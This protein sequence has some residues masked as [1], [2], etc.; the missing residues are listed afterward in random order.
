MGNQRLSQ[1]ILCCLRGVIVWPVL[2]GWNDA[3]RFRSGRTPRLQTTS[4]N[5][6]S[7]RFHRRMVFLAAGNWKCSGCRHLVWTYRTFKLEIRI[8]HTKVRLQA[9]SPGCEAA[10]EEIQD[11]GNW[12]LKTQNK[13]EVN[14]KL[15]VRTENCKAK[16]LADIRLFL[17]APQQRPSASLTS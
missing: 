3:R 15:K 10:K 14:W 6:V 16:K 7:S 11:T 2:I 12:K 5:A 13:V 8:V 9:K 1:K 17:A 4:K